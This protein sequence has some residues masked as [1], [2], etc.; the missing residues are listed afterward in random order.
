MVDLFLILLFPA[1]GLTAI[2]CATWSL[3]RYYASG[4]RAE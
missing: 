4:P 3:W 2:A 1:V